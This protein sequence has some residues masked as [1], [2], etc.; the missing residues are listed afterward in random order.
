MLIIAIITGYF[1]VSLVF[2]IY[3]MRDYDFTSLKRAVIWLTA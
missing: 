3:M 1:M 2:T